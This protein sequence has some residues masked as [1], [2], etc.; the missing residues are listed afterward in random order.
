MKKY[1]SSIL[2]TLAVILFIYGVY[3]WSQKSDQAPTETSAVV[4]QE[5]AETAHDPDQLGDPAPAQ[6]VSQTMAQPQPPERPVVEQ[7]A[8]AMEQL[9]ECLAVPMPLLD[10]SQGVSVS[11]F[12]D[13]LNEDLG[14]VI[15]REDEWTVTDLRTSSGEARR[16]FIQNALGPSGEMERRLKYY[17]VG[18]GGQLTELPLAQEQRMNPTEA[19]MASLESDGVITSRSSSKKIFTQN[20]AEL[21]VAEAQGKVYS[22]EVMFEG[23]SFRCNTLSQCT[24]L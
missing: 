10:A 14:S 17:S 6:T 19:L 24:C 3:R 23:K 7:F 5:P 13:A 2:V 18:D 9:S 15:F 12:E 21:H 4:D 8:S 22:F 1:G 20:G 16:L 11:S